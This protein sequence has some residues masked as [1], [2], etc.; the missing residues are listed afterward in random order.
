[1]VDAV[2]DDLQ[3]PVAVVRL[4]GIGE[5]LSAE[6]RR[7]PDRIDA[8]ANPGNAGRNVVVAQE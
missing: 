4:D 7:Y 6:Y 5:G 3:E 2:V 8:A 1:M